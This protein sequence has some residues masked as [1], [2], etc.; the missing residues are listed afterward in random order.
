MAAKKGSGFRISAQP[1]SP[2][3]TRQKTGNRQKPGVVR[4]QLRKIDPRIKKR[5]KRLRERY[6]E[7]HGKRVDWVEH[8]SVEG[9]L[10]VGIRFQDKTHFSLLFTACVE[11]RFIDLGDMSS[12]DEVILKRYFRKRDD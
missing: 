12:G 8:H 3:R 11:P 7:I 6:K 2:R 9:D 5:H 10:L 1:A 4:P